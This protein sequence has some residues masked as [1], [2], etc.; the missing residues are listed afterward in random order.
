MTWPLETMR[1]KVR[2]LCEEHAGDA[3][4]SVAVERQLERM[5]ALA[6]PAALPPPNVEWTD[7]VVEFSWFSLRH[8][9][10]VSLSVAEPVSLLVL[11]NSNGQTWEDPTD[12]QIKSALTLVES[13]LDESLARCHM[14]IS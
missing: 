4:L 5:Y 9:G 10:A 6:L 13:W 8:Q 3:M 11:M 7:E 14:G 2:E 12:E 1:A